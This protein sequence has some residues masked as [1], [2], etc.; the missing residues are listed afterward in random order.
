MS[1]GICKLPEYFTWHNTH[2]ER[3]KKSCYYWVCGYY[4]GN[5]ENTK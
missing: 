5:L 3:D 1:L 2:S 4:L